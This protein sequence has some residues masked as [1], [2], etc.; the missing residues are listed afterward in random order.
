[1]FQG[2]GTSLPASASR[3]SR[4][5]G[6]SSYLLSG[7]EGPTHQL[8]DRLNNVMLGRVD[9]KDAGKLFTDF[10]CRAVMSEMRLAHNFHRAVLS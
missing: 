6:F 1:M 3:S 8:Q 2:R 7:F 4:N 5:I 9:H 10:K